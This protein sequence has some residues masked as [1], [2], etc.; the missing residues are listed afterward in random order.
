MENQQTK[1]I[2]KSCGKANSLHKPK[3]FL[4]QIALCVETDQLFKVEDEEEKVQTLPQM[5]TK[6]SNKKC[7]DH[8]RTDLN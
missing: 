1:M 7:H 3:G 2:F 8:I 6:E 5:S 4:T